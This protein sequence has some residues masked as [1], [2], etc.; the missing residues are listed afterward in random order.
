M[1]FCNPPSS[2]LRP[3][4]PH[5]ATSLLSS[6]DTIQSNLIHHTFLPGS[7]CLMSLHHHNYNLS[8][9]HETSQSY[10]LSLSL[11]SSNLFPGS[12]WPPRTWKIKDILPYFVLLISW[13][14]LAGRHW[15]CI[16]TPDLGLILIRT[17]K[18][19]I[20]PLQSGPLYQLEVE[21]LYQPKLSLP[22]DTLTTLQW[23]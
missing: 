20:T 7:S 16:T 17:I 8:S 22:S 18:I 23:C 21:L 1:I 10:S 6:H 2:L 11:S 3:H 12:P 14:R 5:M 13:G 4:R 15:H 19:F 9:D